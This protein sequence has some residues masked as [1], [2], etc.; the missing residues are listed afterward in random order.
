MSQKQKIFQLIS[1]G[2]SRPVKK[3]IHDREVETV[4]FYKYL[5]TIFDCKLSWDV[6]TDA[7]VKRG[8]QRVYFLRKLNSFD[9][10]QKILS[11]F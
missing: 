9:V 5:G 2:L 3:V 1:G 8:L 7:I 6:N 11:L 4:S 10:D